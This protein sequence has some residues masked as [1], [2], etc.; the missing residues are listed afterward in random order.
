VAGQETPP[1]E[2]SSKCPACG[3][4]M[5]VARVKPL[6]FGGKFEDLTLACKT[7]GFTKGFRIARS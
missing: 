7:C 6:L 4:E 1:D 2:P 3:T 5:A